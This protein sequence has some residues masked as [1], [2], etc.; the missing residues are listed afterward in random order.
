[1]LSAS[2]SNAYS[3]SLGIL[4]PPLDSQNHI[5]FLDELTESEK[6]YMETLRMIDTQIASIWMKQ[7]TSTAPDFSELLRHVNEISKTNKQFFSKIA[8]ISHQQEFNQTL[9]QWIDDLEV[10]YSSYCRSYIP[11]LKQRTDILSNPFISRLIQDLSGKAS[12]EITL[13]SLFEAP[14]QQLK[15]Y[16][17]LYAKLFDQDTFFNKKI[18]KILALSQKR[19]VLS[20]QTGFESD[21]KIFESQVNTSR[22]MDFFGGTYIVTLI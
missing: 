2:T 6:K 7:T 3:G 5:D 10:P 19:N 8:R 20:I 9:L 16:K 1:M 4:T 12:Y 17:T 15:Y 22:T 14:L 18:D 13:Q 21:L 11:N